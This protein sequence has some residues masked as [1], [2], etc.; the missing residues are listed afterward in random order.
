MYDALQKF[1][2]DTINPETESLMDQYGTRE[3]AF[4]A[5]ILEDLA[6]LLNCG[7]PKITHACKRNREGNILGEI[8]AY[9]ISDNSE[10]LT[11]FYTLY[12]L[13]ED[14]I[15]SY[16]NTD[17][18][19]CINR[20]QGFYKNVALRGTHIDIEDKND[21]LYEPCSTIFENFNNIQ[22]INLCVLSNAIVNKSEEV[23]KIKIVDKR[24]NCDCWD[25]R[26]IYHQ[27]HKES[28]HIEIDLDFTENGEFSKYKI[29]FIGMES[30]QIDYKCILALFPAKFLYELYDK[31]NTNLLK[32][33]VRYFLGFK[34]SKKNANNGMLETLRSNESQMF[35]AYNNG[36]T[37]IAENIEDKPL[38]DKTQVGDSEDT[39]SN[40]K[41]FISVGVLN[42]ILDFQIVNGGQTTAS[43]FNAKKSKGNRNNPNPTPISLIGVYVQVKI[44]VINESQKG[45]LIK[46]ITKYSNSQSAIKYSDFSVSNEF[47]MKMQDLS[48]RILVPSLKHETKYWFFERLRGQFENERNKGKTRADI[49][50][51]DGLYPKNMRFKKEEVAKVWKSWEQTPYDA[52]K[53]E[54][55]NYDLF[56]TDKVNKR[57]IPD[58][59]YY[60]K[61][62]ALLI[63]YRYLMSRPE[64]KEYGNKKATIIAYAIA[65]LEYATFGKLDL[66]K[67][68]E[69]QE[70]SANTKVYLDELCE[71]LSETFDRLAKEKGK[72]VLSYGKVKDAYT[73]VREN[74][75]ILNNELLKSE[76]IES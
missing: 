67:I 5:Y 53:G 11:L 32:N 58:E 33:N 56:I 23:K 3:S 65:Y 49:L 74:L 64:N 63:I 26:K 36:I 37:A 16:S 75:P 17:Y 15:E 43:I 44:I 10:V 7:D 40:Q 9:A 46:N 25:I 12:D 21:P 47:N 19:K 39:T 4:T 52:V 31:Y 51:F 76:L 18:E 57:F 6:E 2:F 73:A 69:N 27:F 14:H 20:L 8:Y 35:L 29:P 60:K 55:T 62:I 59:I 45:K 34:K 30:D 68:W 71:K 42:K 38:T 41:D 61:T 54:G 1:L 50:Y 70:V 22:T 24:I 13:S 28:D 72:T 48:R 66:L